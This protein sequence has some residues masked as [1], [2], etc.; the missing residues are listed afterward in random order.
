MKLRCLVTMATC[1]KSIGSIFFI[2]LVWIVFT[3]TYILIPNTPYL[4]GSVLVTSSIFAVLV[5]LRTYFYNARSDPL[6]SK[7]F[8]VF[9]GTLKPIHI[10]QYSQRSCRNS[11]EPSRISWNILDYPRIIHNFLVSQNFPEFPKKP[12]QFCQFF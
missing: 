5:I 12:C 11:L 9:P 8:L 3:H 1:A 7:N 2:G 6:A 10:P 4:Y